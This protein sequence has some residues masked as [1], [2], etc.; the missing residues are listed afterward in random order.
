MTNGDVRFLDALR[1]IVRD[2]EERSTLEVRSPP[3][4]AV[5]ATM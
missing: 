2:I 3:V 1:V 4:C 5:K